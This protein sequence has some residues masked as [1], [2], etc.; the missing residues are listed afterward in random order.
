MCPATVTTSCCRASL[1]RIA[2]EFVSIIIEIKIYTQ[3]SCNLFAAVAQVLQMRRV[4]RG[5]YVILLV[6]GMFGCDSSD[7]SVAVDAAEVDLQGEAQEVATLMEQV[8]DHQLGLP[9]TVD[10]A[11]PRGWQHCAFYTG[12]M[13]AYHATRDTAYLLPA[14][15]WAASNRWTPGPRLRHAD[16]QCVGQIYLDL[17]LRSGDPR[18]LHPT[19]AAVDRM[20]ENPKPGR[21]DWWWADAL[22]MAPPVF[23][24]LGAVTGNGKYL[25]ALDRKY[26][27]VKAF[28]FDE[29]AGLYY[30]DER[31]LGR[32]NSNGRKVFWSRGNGWVIAGLARVLEAFPAE[33]PTRPRYEHHFRTLASAVAERQKDDGYW[34]SNLADSA[35]HPMPETSGTAFFCYA[36]AWG[37]NQGLLNANQYAPVVRRAWSA[38]V[39]AVNDDGRLGWLQPV[40]SMPAYVERSDSYAFGVGAFLMAGSEMIPF[41]QSEASSSDGG[42]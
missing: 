2:K 28:L 20:I 1:P 42:G 14:V 41:M 16:D 27:D 21:V 40:G 7:T 29:T 15:R 34:R 35:A 26:W 6:V 5:L 19:K 10:E 8:R 37:I 17:H 13:A 38:L 24:R 23:T 25:D 31:F 18:M 30:R 3:P 12:M 9:V 39:R 36:L 11:D 32:R 22:F 4:I 33:Y